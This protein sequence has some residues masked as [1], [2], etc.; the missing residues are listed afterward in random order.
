MAHGC[1][2]L[3]GMG[4]EDLQ[5]VTQLSHATLVLGTDGAP[6]GIGWTV[7]SEWLSSHLFGPDPWYLFLVWDWETCFAYSSKSIDLFTF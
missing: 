1:L 3:T 6:S 7:P 2:V 5:V 4:R